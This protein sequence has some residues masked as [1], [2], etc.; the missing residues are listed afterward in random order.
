MKILGIFHF[1]GYAD[2]SAAVV[3]D[4]SVVAFVEEERLV[5]NKHATAYF[6]SRAVAYVLKEARL[7]LDDIDYI[8]FGWDCH[9]HENGGLSR[10]FDEINRLYPPTSFDVAYQKNRLSSFTSERFRSSIRRELRRMHGKAKLPEIVFVNHHLAHAVSAYFHSNLTDALVLAIDGSGEIDT[11]TWWEARDGKLTAAACREDTTF[12]RVVLL[13]VHG[14]PRVRGV[15]R[16]IQSD[17]TRRLWQARPRPGRKTATTDLVR[18]EG[19]PRIQS[20]SAR[21]G[22]THRFILRSGQ[23][24]RVHG[25]FAPIER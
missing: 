25:P 3:V 20:A 14:I 17:G 16:R 19:R 4:G 10:H 5:R 11:T 2:P 8:S 7:T 18:W 15:R 22:S 6:P 12:A 23:A 13:G 24:Q 21:Y 1:P 9:L